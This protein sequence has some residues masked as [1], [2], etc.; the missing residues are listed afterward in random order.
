MRYNENENLTVLNRFRM[1]NTCIESPI[2]ERMS[3]KAGETE[4]SVITAADED[5]IC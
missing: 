5:V 1:I 3:E 2:V 4:E